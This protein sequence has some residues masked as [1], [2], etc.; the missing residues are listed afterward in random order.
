[1]GHINRSENMT[2]SKVVLSQQVAC[3]S[4]QQNILIKYHKYLGVR[5]KDS[6]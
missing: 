5:E 1:M 2:V 6:K 3:K 4:I